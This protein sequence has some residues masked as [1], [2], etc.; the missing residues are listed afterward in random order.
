MGR[1]NYYYKYI[2][3]KL[4][5][6]IQFKVAIIGENKKIRQWETLDRNSNRKYKV[7]QSV[8]LKIEYSNPQGKAIPLQTNKGVK[9]VLSIGI[10]GL[11]QSSI[12]LQ[13]E[14]KWIEKNSFVLFKMLSIRKQIQINEVI[15]VNKR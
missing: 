3:K 8:A 10:L 5:Q 6:K 7:T 14:P 13:L 12:N 9:G 1:I 11:N 15:V 2:I 4:D